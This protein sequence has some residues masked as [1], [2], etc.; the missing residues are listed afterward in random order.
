[1][2]VDGLM[3]TFDTSSDGIITMNEFL[4]NMP[5]KLKEKLLEMAGADGF[6]KALQ[7]DGNQRKLLPYF[8]KYD[9]D[10]DGKLTL[11][12]FTKACADLPHTKA[13]RLSRATPWAPCSTG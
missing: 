11:P 4:F 13:S 3:D 9:E 5:E 6:I 2:G 8:K 1:M 12:E 10:G 7:D